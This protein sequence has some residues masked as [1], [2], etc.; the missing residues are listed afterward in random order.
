MQLHDENP[1]NSIKS[2]IVLLDGAQI[3]WENN[4]K[5][6]YS[7]A[8]KHSFPR[9]F[10]YINTP[11]FGKPTAIIVDAIFIFSLAKQYCDRFIDL[12]L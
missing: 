2:S 10:R 7:L 1:R 11:L 4:R 5:K 3:N 9:I 8:I 6:M 12:Y